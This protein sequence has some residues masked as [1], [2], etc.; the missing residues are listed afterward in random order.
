MMI[1][2]ATQRATKTTMTMKATK[3]AKLIISPSLLHV[4]PS[5]MKGKEKPGLK[6]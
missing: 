1:P 4:L 5:L 6:K 3:K 2:A